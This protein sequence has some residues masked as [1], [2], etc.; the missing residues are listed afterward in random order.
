M[1]N[2]NKLCIY[3]IRYLP[4]IIEYIC[5]FQFNF[6]MSLPPLPISLKPIQQYIKLAIDHESRDA[7]VAYYCSNKK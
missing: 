3:P 7:V 6:I 4:I 5:N 1:F 2:N